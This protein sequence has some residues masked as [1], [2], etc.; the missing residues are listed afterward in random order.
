MIVTVSTQVD[1]ASKQ[2]WTE[3]ADLASHPEWMSDAESIVFTSDRN[4]GVG[5]TMDVTTRV[6]PLRTTDALEVTDWVEGESI[7]IAH[8][9]VVKGI[10]R[11]EVVPKGGKRSVVTWTEELVFPWWIGGG[12]SAIVAKP[13]LTRIWQANLQRLAARVSAL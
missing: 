5:T 1:A 6:G 2:V 12:V 10:G 13:F 8:R 4:R 3:L 9:G 7:E 11:L